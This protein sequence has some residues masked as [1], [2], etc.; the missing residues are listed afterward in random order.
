[1]RHSPPEREQAPTP[2][3]YHHSQTKKYDR[4]EYNIVNEF[5]ASALVVSDFEVQ[6]CQ[7]IFSESVRCHRFSIPN[8]LR[9][10]YPR[11]FGYSKL[12]RAIQKKDF[13]LGDPPLQF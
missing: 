2:I 11:Q 1:M 5:Q 8:M 13:N 12:K 10:P 9:F 6:C 4:L 3:G 7:S